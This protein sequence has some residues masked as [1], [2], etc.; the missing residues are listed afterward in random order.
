M[1]S[2]GYVVGSDEME[3]LRVEHVIDVEDHLS[4]QPICRGIK[5]SVYEI[6]PRISFNC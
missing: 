5:W 1:N 3:H 2:L 6:V 4:Q